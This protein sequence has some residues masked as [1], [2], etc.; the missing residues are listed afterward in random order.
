MNADIDGLVRGALD[1]GMV[2]LDTA[3]GYQRGRNEEMIGRVLKGRP[4]ESFVIA[5]KVWDGRRTGL[6]SA[7]TTAIN[8]WR[9]SS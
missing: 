1:A 2:H 9:S 6:F 7:E 3:H 5:T 4:R 8:S